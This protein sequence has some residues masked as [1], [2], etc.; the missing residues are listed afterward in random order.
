LPTYSPASESGRGT[1][2]F[3][4]PNYSPP[5]LDEADEERARV[6]AQARGVSKRTADGDVNTAGKKRRKAVKD[7]DEW[8]SDDDDDDGRGSDEKDEEEE[9]EE[10]EEEPTSDE[11]EE[12]VK[13][14]A[15]SKKKASISSLGRRRETPSPFLTFKED[16]GDGEGNS[17]T[18]FVSDK[19]HTL[20][21]E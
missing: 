13:K 10:P 7:E 5:S 21:C 12:E 14:P 19:D 4:A 11:E 2:V 15:A 20:H 18:V 16:F 17:M 6:R 9:E 1:N 8:S 3:G